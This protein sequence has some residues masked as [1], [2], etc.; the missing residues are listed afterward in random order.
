[1]ESIYYTGMDVHKD[2]VSIV[3]FKDNDVKP[4]IVV[5]K[6]NQPSVLKK[7]FEKLKSKGIIIA[8]Y[9]AGFSGFTLY[10]MLIEMSIQCVVAAPGLLP[11]KPGKRIKTDRLDAQALAKNLRNEEITSIYVPSE[12]DEAVRDYLRMYED[13]KIDLK[14][15]KQRLNSYLIRHG[16]KYVGNKWTGK[17]KAWLKS[18]T[19]S[20]QI[21]QNV[22]D[23]YFYRIKDLEDKISLISDEVER[24]SQTEPYKEKV[25]KL[26]CLKGIDTL[27]AINLVIEL[28]DFRRFMTA[29]EFM[30][31]LGLVPSETTSGNKRRQGSI[32]KAGNSHL[33]RL[34]V[35]AGWHYQ[36]YKPGSKRMNQKRKGMSREI[37]SYADKA[38][39]RLSKKFINMLLR[40][41]KSQVAVI[42]VTRE[43][44]GFI[45]GLM[46]GKIY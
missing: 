10:R 22:F 5:K 9:E 34:L 14:K 36:S 7:F 12:E 39:R 25:D 33:R 37:V 20:N 32:T 2:S 27:I 24:I 46:V 16:F 11:K 41:K 15:A 28:G 8:C 40:Y 29:A 4:E 6:P 26:R 19:F 31:Y 23:E 38:G 44:A 43:L 35:E 17:H 13:Y 3:V 42:A 1:M 30:A 45:W 18:L 21:Q